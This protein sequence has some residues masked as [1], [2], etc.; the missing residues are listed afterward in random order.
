MGLQLTANEISSVA[1]DPTYVL[2]GRIGAA[3]LY[4]ASEAT[5]YA[6]S[7]A[8]GFEKENAYAEGFTFD[9]WKPSVASG[10]SWIRASFSATQKAAY[11]GI[12]AHDLQNHGV[13]GLK[14]QYGRVLSLDVSG[15][16]TQSVG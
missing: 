6:S 15:E 8:T 14:A 9:F 10:R 11:L 3:N 4:R 7:E 1:N 13:T 5:V 12:A 2:K 16:D